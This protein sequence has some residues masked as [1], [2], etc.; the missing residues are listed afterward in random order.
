MAQVTGFAYL[1]PSYLSVHPVFGP[2]FALRA[3]VSVNCLA[4]EV[5]GAIMVSPRPGL[6]MPKR[7]C[8]QLSDDFVS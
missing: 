3:A 1:T 4:E 2:W 5:P 6:F 7:A 8:V